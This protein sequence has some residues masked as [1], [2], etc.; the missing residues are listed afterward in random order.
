MN[1]L[2]MPNLSSD[3]S[4][5]LQYPS[6]FIKT[7]SYSSLL[8]LFCS[9]VEDLLSSYLKDVGISEEQ[10][11]Q[12]CGAPSVQSRPQMQVCIS[13]LLYYITYILQGKVHALGQWI[14]GANAPNS[15]L[16]LYIEVP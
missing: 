2:Y 1:F 7:D 4:Y 6:A 8:H 13:L 11:V 14:L 12:A 10:F 9:Q 15:L 3:S 16:M 5:L